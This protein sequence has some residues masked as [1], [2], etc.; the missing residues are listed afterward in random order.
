MPDLGDKASAFNYHTA[1]GVGGHCHGLNKGNNQYKMYN[2]AAEVG[3]ADGADPTTFVHGTADA[4]L[5]LK[6][7]KYTCPED[8]VYKFNL[9][10]M[11]ENFH[12]QCS[13]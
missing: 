7:G 3:D 1:G 8:G 5:D 6:T 11:Y 2:S 13:V 9:N 12:G 4:D 10:F